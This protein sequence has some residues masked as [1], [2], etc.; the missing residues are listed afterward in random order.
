M[1]QA[2]NKH[3]AQNLIAVHGLRA[4]AVVQERLAEAR[5]QGDTSGLERWQNVE[6]AI[7]ELRRTVPRESARG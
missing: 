3:T 2:E 6:A 5:Q 4:Q 7:S 1:S